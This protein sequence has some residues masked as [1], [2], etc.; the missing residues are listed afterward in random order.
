MKAFSVK[1]LER[2]ETL[3]SYSKEFETQDWLT[4][5]DI[6]KDAIGILTERYDSVLFNER[7]LQEFVSQIKR[8]NHATK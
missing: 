6:L 5:A 8:E 2:D 7:N 3:I 4:K 1:W